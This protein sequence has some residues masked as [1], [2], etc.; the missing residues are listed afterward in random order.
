MNRSLAACL[1]MTFGST[2]VPSASLADPNGGATIS[3]RYDDLNLL[4][5]EGVKV[6]DRRIE[7]AVDRVCVDSSRGARE[8]RV[9]LACRDDALAAAHA[10]MPQAI[11]PQHFNKSP[12]VAVRDP[13]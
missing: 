6:L 5:P 4:T 3:V 11:A 13:R 2:I 1:A 7:R 8:A 12:V 10:Q 9:D